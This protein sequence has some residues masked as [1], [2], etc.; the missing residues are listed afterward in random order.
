MPRFRAL[1]NLVEVMQPEDGQV[2]PR[3]SLRQMEG[4]SVTYAPKTGR[5]W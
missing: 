2:E 5:L 4:F 3:A 1:W